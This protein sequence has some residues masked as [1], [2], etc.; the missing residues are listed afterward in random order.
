MGNFGSAIADAVGGGG[1]ASGAQKRTGAV[2]FSSQD[3][4]PELALLVAQNLKAA[5]H[6]DEVGVVVYGKPAKCL[7]ELQLAAQQHSVRFYGE[8]ADVKKT[9]GAGYVAW[10]GSTI[11]YVVSCNP[12]EDKA[13]VEAGSTKGEVRL[14]VPEH[15]ARDQADFGRATVTLMRVGVGLGQG[16]RVS[17]TVPLF[18][19]CC[20][21]PGPRGAT[22]DP[23]PFVATNSRLNSPAADA[24]LRRKW[25]QWIIDSKAEC[26][27]G[28]CPLTD[29]NRAGL[30]TQPLN[31]AFVGRPPRSPGQKKALQAALENFFIEAGCQVGGTN[32]QALC[33][34]VLPQEQAFCGTANGVAKEWIEG[35]EVSSQLTVVACQVPIGHVRSLLRAACPRV[36]FVNIEPTDL[37]VVHAITEQCDIYWHAEEGRPEH[38]FVKAATLEAIMT[39]TGQARASLAAR[40]YDEPRRVIAPTFGNLDKAEGLKRLGWNP[41]AGGS[42]RGREDNDKDTAEPGST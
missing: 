41:K 30:S 40:M 24:V 31:V 9:T 3:P 19:Q 33:M 11:G 26:Y 17:N 42:K 13:L 12:A 7:A 18:D 2:L 16:N 10:A 39:Q 8:W 22:L 38:A 25:E 27:S 20:K 5:G 14:V 28:M 6:V 23:N 36:F 1:G 34:I 29:K 21:L 15:Q 37:S 4:C 32:H 35:L